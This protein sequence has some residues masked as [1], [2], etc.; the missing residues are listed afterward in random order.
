MREAWEPVRRYMI[1]F[2]SVERGQ[3]VFQARVAIDRL[4]KYIEGRSREIERIDLR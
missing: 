4:G 1:F 2:R 3:V